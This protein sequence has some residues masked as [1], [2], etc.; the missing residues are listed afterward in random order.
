MVYEIGISVCF[1]VLNWWKGKYVLLKNIMWPQIWYQLYLTIMFSY[2]R[3]SRHNYTF[4]ICNILEM[5]RYASN[6]KARKL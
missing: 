1:N 6:Y 2:E 4:I 5:Q 3:I